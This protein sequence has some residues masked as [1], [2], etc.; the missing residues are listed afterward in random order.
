MT[1][2]IVAPQR[3]YTTEGKEVVN[4]KRVF[5]LAV[6]L[7]LLAHQAYA[8]YVIMLRSGNRIVAKEK[9]TVKG[10]NAVFETKTGAFTSIPLSQI[11]LESTEKINSLN[12]G[13]VQTLDWVDIQKTTPTPTP[14]VPVSSLGRLRTGLAKPEAEAAKP[15][16]TPGVIYRDKRYH[17]PQVDQAFQ[18]GLESYHL[19]L[20]RT[21]Q[22]T[23]PTYLFIEL[24]V[25]GQPETLKA[26]QAVTQTYQLLADKA[27]NRVPER[28][29]LQ[30]LNE[31]GKEAGVFRISAADA[32]AL[33][34]GKITAENFFIQHVIF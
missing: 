3:R 19:Y 5:F 1:I 29:E 10:P 16:P 32:A 2:S 25:N 33:V 22:G 28:V 24:Q 30:M 21:S 17:D 13:D 6:A 4:V 20:Y 7:L 9:Y 8:V 18:Q 11:D 15:T 31:S 23:Q 34:S 26:L 14:T 12:L 27:P